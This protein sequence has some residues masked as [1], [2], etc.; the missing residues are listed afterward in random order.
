VPP[1]T[2]VYDP[3]EYWKP[4][5]LTDPGLRRRPLVSRGAA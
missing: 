2:N 3:N 4:A 5:A 1:G